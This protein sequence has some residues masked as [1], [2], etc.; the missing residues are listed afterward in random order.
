MCKPGLHG[1]VHVQAWLAQDASLGQH[2]KMR[3]E[4]FG[5]DVIVH[6]VQRGARQANIV[7]DEADRW[8]FL[9]LLRYLND[10]SVPRNWEREIAP[11][12]IRAGF[13]RPDQWN[14]PQPY[15][16]ILAYC[17]MDNHFHILLQERM[18]N[19]IAKFM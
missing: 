9:R 19:G 12:H 4:T 15:V 7:R 8:R 6:V 1:E 5:E 11:E 10:E 18:E 17:L 13:T 2:S 3:K 16:S 14:E